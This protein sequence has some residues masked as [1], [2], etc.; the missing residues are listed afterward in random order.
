M[1]Q[2]YGKQNQEPD[3]LANMNQ[4]LFWFKIYA[5]LPPSN[6]HSRYSSFHIWLVVN[7]ITF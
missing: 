1:S 5:K 6:L 4:I 7:F 3:K 2:T